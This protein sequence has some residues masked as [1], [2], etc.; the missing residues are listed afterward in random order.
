MDERHVDA[1]PFERI[2]ESDTWTRPCAAADAEATHAR[3]A[4]RLRG[5]LARVKRASDELRFRGE[6]REQ[7]AAMASVGADMLEEFQRAHRASGTLRGGVMAQGEW[8]V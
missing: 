7:L 5:V 1:S 2:R 3:A 8:L 6:E 4:E